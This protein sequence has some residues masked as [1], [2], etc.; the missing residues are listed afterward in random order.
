MDIQLQVRGRIIGGWET[1][2]IMRAIDQLASSF[3]LSIAHLEMP[4]PFAIGEAV[5]LMI[6]S[7]TVLTGHLE[8]LEV[9]HHSAERRVHIKGRSACGD[10]IDG[11]M[12]PPLNWRQQTLPQVLGEICAPYGITIEDQVGI[13]T[14]GDF[15]AVPGERVFD[16][17][18]RFCRQYAVW[19]T[20]DGKDTL[21]L[22]RFNFPLWRPIQVTRE[23][24]K[25]ARSCLD[26]RE[27][28]AAY[29]C[30]SQFEDHASPQPQVDIVAET[31]DAAIARHRPHL[32]YAEQSSTLQQVQDRA[33]WEANIR[34]ARSQQVMLEVGEWQAQKQLWAPGYLVQVDD[35]WIGVKGALLIAGVEYRRD[36]NGS[37]T[38]LRLV[39]PGVFDLAP[40]APFA[41]FF[42][43]YA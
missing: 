34:A 3:E 24:I 28:F 39:P 31:A 25:S 11:S 36:E 29:H 13:I 35:D 19:P 17:I 30:L 38:L 2:R 27:R 26:T 37:T 1:A 18:D 40:P 8:M 21:I 4:L 5:E 41:D 32:L 9:V 20:S 16:V 23:Q 43:D 7:E 42:P 6:G 33:L 22:K 12:I 10:L 15:N 14:V